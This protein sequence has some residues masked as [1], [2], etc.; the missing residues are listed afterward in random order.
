MSRHLRQKERLDYR[1]LH[2]I[3][4][5]DSEAATLD[6]NMAQRRASEEDNNVANEAMVGDGE[7][8]DVFHDSVMYHPDDE[9]D[10]DAKLASEMKALE[11]EEKK[12]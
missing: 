4:K 12:L 10:E 1:H 2:E 11:L 8:Q 6:E 3:G 7:E 9:P 5:S